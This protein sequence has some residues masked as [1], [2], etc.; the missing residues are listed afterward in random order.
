MR[1]GILSDT[2]GALHPA[3][4]ELFAGVA[5]IL[6]AGDVGTE[7]VLDE[8]MAIAPVAA[9]RGNTDDHGSLDRLPE[10]LVLERED[11]RIVVLHGHLVRAAKP[12]ILL[13][14]TRDARPDLVVYGHTHVPLHER[15][16]GVV[17]FNPGAAGKPQFRSKPTIGLLEIAA[18]G[19]R[20]SHHALPLPWPRTAES[21]LGGVV[22]GAGQPARRRGGDG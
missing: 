10:R 4:P 17:F 9:V 8:L 22:A 6:H 1:Y 12:E 7:R 15:R 3:V 16:A 13:E 21:R 20:L 14:H 11:R 18:D 19:L 5:E 2:H